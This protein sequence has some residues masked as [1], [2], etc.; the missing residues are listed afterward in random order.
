MG[1]RR[2]LR[3][4]V[5]DEQRSTSIG[6]CLL[7]RYRRVAQREGHGDAARS[8]YAPLSGDMRTTG[9]HQERDTCLCQVRGAGEQS[10]SGGGRAL[11]QIAVA[12]HPIRAD[13]GGAITVSFG[14][15]YKRHGAGWH[16][17]YPVLVW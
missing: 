17:A 13:H 5:S 4:G 11:H 10:G 15:G 6:D 7:E 2:S 8:P 9:R 12:E 14:A 3:A 16:D 1:A